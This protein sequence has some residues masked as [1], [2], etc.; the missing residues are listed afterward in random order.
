MKRIEGDENLFEELYITPTAL[1]R[2]FGRAE[3]TIREWAMKCEARRITVDGRVKY[4]LPD[5]LTF[6]L[7]HIY[8]PPLSDDMEKLKIENEK[9]KAELGRLRLEKE[10]GQLV[11]R[12]LV[13]TEWSQRV[14]EFRQGLIALE[15]K[16]AK[17]LS[18]RKLTLAQVRSLVR[19]KVL[20]ILRAYSRDGIYT[21]KPDSWP[22]EDFEVLYYKFLR[23][24]EKKGCRNLKKVKVRIECNDKV[25][26][27]RKKS[28]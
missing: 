11:E 16:L 10:K 21:P 26:G 4:F 27:K 28:S 18:G 6:Y 25:N 3:S 9:I 23:E 17:E 8:K 7:A 14:A 12:D 2:L 15:F 13:E 1:A 20:E 19:D 5:L 22:P 24:L